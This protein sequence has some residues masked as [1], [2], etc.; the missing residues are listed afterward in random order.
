MTFFVFLCLWIFVCF[1]QLLITEMVGKGEGIRKGLGTGLEVWI[2][3]NT[4]T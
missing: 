3:Y 1:K 2:Q 4:Y